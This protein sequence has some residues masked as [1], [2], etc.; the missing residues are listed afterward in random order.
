MLNDKIKI[1]QFEKQKVNPVNLSHESK[2]NPIE[3]KP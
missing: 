1:N 3:G 2:I